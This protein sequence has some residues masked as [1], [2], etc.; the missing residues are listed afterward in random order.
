MDALQGEIAETAY[1]FEKFRLSP[2]RQTLVHGTRSIRLGSRAME[3]LRLLVER[4]GELI[5]KADL[6]RQA[7]P[8]TFVHEGNLKVNIAALRRALREAGG[9]GPYIATVSGRGYRFVAPVRQERARQDTPGVAQ[10][11]A[12]ALP[13]P[14]TVIGRDGEIATITEHLAARRFVTIVGT[15]GVG[16]T[17]VAV[18]AAQRM[19]AVYPD[20]LCFVDLAAIGDPQFVTAAIAAAIGSGGNLN[21]LLVGIVEA[22]RGRRCLLILDNCEHV[23]QAAA[24]AAEHI[25]TG[26]PGLPILATSREPLRNRTETVLRLAPLPCPEDPAGICSDQALAFPSVALFVARATE[27]AGYRITD[28]DAPVV[29]AICRRVDGLPLAIELAASR[30]RS[31]GPAALLDLL[32]HSFAP[33]SLGPS[34]AP[35]RQQALVSTLDWSYRLLSADEA[36]ALRLVSVFAGRFTLEDSVGVAGALGRTPEE[37]AA[38]LESLA[39]KSLLSF[40][41]SETGPHYRL[42]ETTRAYAAD[43]LR[44]AGEHHRTAAAHARFLLAMFECAEAEWQWRVREEWTFTYGRH[45][46]DLRKAIDW[47]FGEEGDPLLGLRL[48]AAAIPL[49]DEMSSIGESRLRVQRSLQSEALAGCDPSLRMKLTT[50]HAWGMAFAERLEGV[51]EAS[52]IESLRL[53]EQVG[54]VDYRLRALWGLAS[55]RSFT[56]RHRLALAPLARFEQLA[57]QASDDSA[58]AAGERLRLI[59]GFYCGN[60]RGVREKLER[61]A[62]RHNHPARRSR[63]S[64]FQMDHYV[65]IR[66]SLAFVSW[67]CGRPEEAMATAQAALD[68]AIEIEHVVSQ[69]NALAQALIPI[70]LWTGQVGLAEHHLA[71]LVANLNRRDLA[72]WGPVGRFFAGAVDGERGLQQMS[73]ALDELVACN[74]V[75][76]APMFRSMLAEAALR[77]GKIDVARASMLPALDLAER[78][79]PW[80]LPEALRVQGLLR[81]Q[82]GDRQ[83]AEQSLS[84]AVA[85]AVES[86]ALGLELRARQSLA[87]LGDR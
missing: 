52:W 80:C 10:V 59:T 83:G 5:G 58:A 33:L 4:P 6:I 57:D 51:A 45:L 71:I 73:D 26:V 55:L 39:A 50:A 19:A 22:L 17:T 61:L 60:M 13:G 3:L 66:V 87:N 48:T 62:R 69:T 7:W 64:R 27:A 35:F 46:N 77:H 43:R 53:A 1:C 82:E 63:I 44:G 54:D 79:E 34:H 9:E 67:V 11:L 30:L 86:G 24:L 76:R 38:T 72:I 49:W 42:L 18:A 28:A 37:L 16:K 25:H 20:G 21:D 36:A 8:D 85:I 31:Y 75:I 65:G 68:G 32:E 78:E 70:A 81:W 15:A 47:A 23:L 56:G 12:N 14:G 41:Y 2:S 74:V 29:A 84:R 40:G